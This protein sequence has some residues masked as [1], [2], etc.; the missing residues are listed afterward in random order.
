MV[1][2][3]DYGAFVE[4]EEGVEGLIHV[5]EMSWTKKVVNPSKILNVGDEVEAIVSELDT[6]A[7]AHLAS[8][9]QI[10]RNPWEELSDTHP[11]GT[12]IEGKV[13]NL[14]EFGAFVEIT[15]GI[16]GL[17][18][19]SDMSWTKRVK[20][21][22]EVLKKGDL[23][24]RGSPTSTSRTSACRSSIKEF[25]PNEWEE[26]FADRHRSATVRRRPGRQRHRLRPLR[27]HLR[28]PR[29]PGPR[30][31][32]D[33][34][35]G[36]TTTTSQVGQTCAMKG[37]KLSPSTS[38]K[39]VGLAPGASR[40]TSPRSDRGDLFERVGQPEATLGDHFRNRGG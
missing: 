30:R 21:P 36:G 39:K 7:A 14:T 29:G 23:V 35:H 38:D 2:L 22:R 6:T 37:I 15:E 20:H 33:D 32:I 19:V 10:E 13:R 4:I 16:D 12:I 27:R 34:S 26:F 31:E 25:L 28:R 18:H 40:A 5:S 9:R 8:L 17:I 11:V 3:V 24:G 1:S